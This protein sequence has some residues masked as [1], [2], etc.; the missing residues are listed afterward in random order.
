[1]WWAWFCTCQ[2]WGLINRCAYPAGSCSEE[3][4]LCRYKTL[5]SGSWAGLRIG[6]GEGGNHESMV[7]LERDAWRRIMGR[8]LRH[9]CWTGCTEEFLQWCLKVESRGPGAILWE[10][11][12]AQGALPPQ[13][14]PHKSVRSS[15]C[16]LS[17][18][19]P[20]N[21]SMPHLSQLLLSSPWLFRHL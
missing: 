18:V 8:E 2:T 19:R 16:S 3:K 14:W 21:W 1:M 17:A 5:V 7:E 11:L 13:K 9:C 6:G 10:T 12:L 4:F 15:V 20:S